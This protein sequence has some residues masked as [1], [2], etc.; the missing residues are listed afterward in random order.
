MIILLSS[1]LNRYK[2][3]NVVFHLIPFAHI[4][5]EK[6]PSKLLLEQRRRT[7]NLSASSY[8]FLPFCFPLREFSPFLFLVQVRETVTRLVHCL[9]D[10]SF[11]Y[12]S[13]L[14]S[15]ECTKEPFAKTFSLFD[16]VRISWWRNPFSFLFIFII[17]YSF[18]KETSGYIYKRSKAN[19]FVSL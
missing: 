1:D 12:G 3:S 4:Q 16:T 15:G 7:R 5:R 18:P 9:L 19:A 10:D 2:G 6:K 17:F 8:I 11:S 14:F 13:R